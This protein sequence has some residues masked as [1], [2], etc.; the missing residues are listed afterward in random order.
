MTY[1]EGPSHRESELNKTE[2]MIR[3]HKRWVQGALSELGY[4]LKLKKD[5]DYWMQMTARLE[6]RVSALERQV[7]ARNIGH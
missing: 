7:E 5:L 2:R 3:N 1:P 4:V 6:S